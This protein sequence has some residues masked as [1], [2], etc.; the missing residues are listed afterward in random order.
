M[1]VLVSFDLA[2]RT[3]P[4]DFVLGSGWGVQRLGAGL[5]WLWSGRLDPDACWGEVK[6]IEVGVVLVVPFQFDDELGQE[7]EGV[8]EL[9]C[10]QGSVS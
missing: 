3:G 1:V 9:R 4:K 5:G 10:D 8:K 6:V 7:G 2:Q